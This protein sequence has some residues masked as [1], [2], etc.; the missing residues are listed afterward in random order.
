VEFG[1]HQTRA[2]GLE[3]RTYF[4]PYVIIDIYIRCVPDWL[5]AK[6]ET[7]ELAEHRIAETTRK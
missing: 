2:T 5:L 4:H 3:K 7:A 6:R 1:Y